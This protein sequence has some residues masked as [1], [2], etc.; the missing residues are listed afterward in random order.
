MINN[1][2]AGDSGEVFIVHEE[3]SGVFG[4][5]VDTDN[6]IAVLSLGDNLGYFTCDS[7]QY[8]SE[9]YIFII[10]LKNNPQFKTWKWISDL[11]KERVEVFTPACEAVKI[12]WGIK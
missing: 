3:L 4:Y 6:W 7:I 1:L 10:H 12:L 9:D 8:E 2:K 11:Q 5:F